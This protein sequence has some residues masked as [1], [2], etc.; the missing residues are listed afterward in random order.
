[1]AKGFITLEHGEDF[2]TRWTGYELIL[3]IVIRELNEIENGIQLADWLKTMQ[4]RYEG[5]SRTLDLRGLTQNNRIL[6]WLGVEK[7][8]EK[9]TELGEKY[10]PLKK[11]RI[12][13]LLY[14]HKTNPYELNYVSETNEFLEIENELIEKIGPGW[15][16]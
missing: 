8:V 15:K 9:I 13:E 5:E 3:K 10:S 12:F 16:N 7:G 6:F 1:M 4:P 2:Y 14:M 11:E